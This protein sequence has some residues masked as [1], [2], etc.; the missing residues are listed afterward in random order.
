[1]Q[2]L[3]LTVTTR[4][5]K[6]ER[7]LRFGFNRHP[8]HESD[9]ATNH[10]PFGALQP[11]GIHV[12]AD[13]NVRDGRLLA[14]RVVLDGEALVAGGEGYISDDRHFRDSS[15]EGFQ[16][17][18]ARAKERQRLAFAQDQVCRAAHDEVLGPKRV[19]RRGI[20]PERGLSFAFFQLRDFSQWI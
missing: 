5:G 1:M 7:G 11:P 4:R 16:S 3:I 17:D 18:P 15:L 8:R 19:E 20:V 13:D 14:R 10:L 6:K 2:S 12:A 9:V